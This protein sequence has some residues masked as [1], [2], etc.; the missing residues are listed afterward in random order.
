MQATYSMAATSLTD[1]PQELL[2]RVLS[3]L[4]PSDIV[5]FG[6]TCRQAYSFINPGNQ[7]LWVST[8]A[9]TAGYAQIYTPLKTLLLIAAP[10]C[11]VSV[12]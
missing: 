6:K 12:C 7:L 9:L 8:D 10:L 1:L 2:G 5:R 4:L 3:F 11:S